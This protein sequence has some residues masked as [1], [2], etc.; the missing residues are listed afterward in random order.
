MKRLLP[1]LALIFVS[2]SYAKIAEISDPNEVIRSVAIKTSERIDLDAERLKR[3]PSYIKVVIDEE[4]MPYID[5]KYAAYKV[6]GTHLKDTTEKQ[7]DEFVETFKTY[8][9]NVYGHM[10]L[11]YD[12]QEIKVLDN[13]NYEDSSII[14][15][16]VHVTDKNG[17]L[18]KL[19]FKLRKNK[20][21]LEWKVFDVVAEGISMLSTK[22]SEINEL[23]EK[24]GI[25]H[26]IKLLNE[27]N[28]ELSS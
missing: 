8:L 20:R 17:K 14:S 11:E 25:D 15:V 10:L 24:N 9:V 3:E 22:Q 16:A 23:I 7:R 21:T 12:Q 18:T 2:C 27:K 4:L 28:S 1:I 19:A 26:V 13:R 6:M 5:Y